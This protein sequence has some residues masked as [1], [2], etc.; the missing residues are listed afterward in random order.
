MSVQASGDPAAYEWQPCSIL[1]PRIGTM[2]SR[3]G[4][5]TRLILPGHYLVR[6]SRTLGGRIYR[7][8][9]GNGDDPS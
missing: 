1:F 5:H 2:L 7:R 9:S 4:V 6:R 8:A 3:H